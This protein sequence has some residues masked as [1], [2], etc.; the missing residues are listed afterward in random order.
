MVEVDGVW[1]LKLVTILEPRE[2]A[3][4]PAQSEEARRLKTRSSRRTVPIHP[5][6]TELGLLDFLR[7]APDD[8]IAFSNLN[9]HDK[10]QWSR[11]PREAFDELLKATGV[12]EARRKVP[13]SVRSNCHQSL[14]KTGLNQDAIQR[15]LGHATK[16]MGDEHYGETEDGPY[17]AA[18]LV[19][20]HMEMVVYPITFPTWTEILAHRRAPF[21]ARDRRR[22]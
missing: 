22:T 13:H 20:T 19:L 7:D 21:A 14:K 9:W 16:Q 11:K 1:C 8:D 18:R 17:V 3:N 6:L 5:K 10:D 2:G 15:V 4:R 12:H